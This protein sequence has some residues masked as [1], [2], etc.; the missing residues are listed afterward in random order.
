[1][2]L[3]PRLRTVSTM[4]VILSTKGRGSAAPILI[5]TP[6]V[7]Q[8]EHVGDLMGDFH[9]PS[10]MWDEDHWRLWF[11]YWAPGVALA[12]AECYGNPMDSANWKITHDL[13]S[14]LLDEWPN[15]DV[16]R[17]G[18]KYY[19]VSDPGNWPQQHSH[20]WMRRQ[21][22][23]AISDDGP[24]A[25]RGPDRMLERGLR[26]IDVTVRQAMSRVRAQIVSEI[27][28]RR[29]LLEFSREVLP[30]FYGFLDARSQSA[31]SQ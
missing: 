6:E 30:F 28:G 31:V 17:L 11:D 19:S 25:N 24:S 12:H 23:Q 5:Y 1:M 7:G 18:D 4:S 14:P 10:L 16:V 2:G 3:G 29:M 26:T 9:R 20:S 8:M 21:I 27:L 22:A 13:S 15:P